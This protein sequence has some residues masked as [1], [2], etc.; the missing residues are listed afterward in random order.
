MLICANFT[1]LCDKTVTRYSKK[2]QII[3]KYDAG[4]I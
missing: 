1:V 4:A 2:L 3:Y